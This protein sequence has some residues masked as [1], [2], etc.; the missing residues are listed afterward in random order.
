MDRLDKK[1]YLLRYKPLI[2]IA[3]ELGISHQAISQ[4]LTNGFPK[5]RAE[6]LE[7]ISSGQIKAE[8]LLK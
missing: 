4:F 8:E 1:F 2:Q 5:N 7:Q 6:Q 3:K